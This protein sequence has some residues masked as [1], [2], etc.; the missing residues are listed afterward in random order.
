MWI[1]FAF[2]FFNALSHFIYIYISPRLQAQ[3]SLRYAWR[4]DAL[5]VR[6]EVR[7]LFVGKLNGT[8]HSFQ[9]GRLSKGTWASD[10]AKSHSPDTCSI[11]GTWPK[12][13]GGL[14][15]PLAMMESRGS[16]ECW[17]QCREL[18][19]GDCECAALVNILMVSLRGGWDYE[20]AILSVGRW[21][22]RQSGRP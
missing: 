12:G 5:G 22:D 4:R 6:G 21:L 7:P 9:A 10:L 16:G 8:L 13:R 14:E 11:E 15:W 2:D 19:G 1:S 3:G 20:L 18:T 17:K